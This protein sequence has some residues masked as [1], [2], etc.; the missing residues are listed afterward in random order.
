MSEKKGKQEVLEKK[1]PK[2]KKGQRLVQYSDPTIV[3]KIRKDRPYVLEIPVGTTIAEEIYFNSIVDAI[4]GI[5]VTVT[6]R[7]FKQESTTNPETGETVVK[8]VLLKTNIL[9]PKLEKTDEGDA[10]FYSSTVENTILIKKN[11][12]QTSSSVVNA[13][14]NSKKSK[15]SA[16]NTVVEELVAYARYQ[17]EVVKVAIEELTAELDARVDAGTL[18]EV[19]DTCTQS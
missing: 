7:L 18:Q 12:P 10:Y 13:T 15:V 11:R 3:R 17:I 14:T 9:S 6:E 4:D 2:L 5:E 16:M 1:R 8:N 19:Q